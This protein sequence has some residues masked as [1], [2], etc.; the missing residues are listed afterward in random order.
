MQPTPAAR[1]LDNINA[2]PEN[3][4]S[5]AGQGST[6]SL[7]NVVDP[8]YVTRPVKRPPVEHQ[9]QPGAGMVAGN[10]PNYPP[11]AGQGSQS[12][13]DRPSYPRDVDVYAKPMKRRPQQVEMSK[14]DDRIN[15]ANAAI[16]NEEQYHSAE[17]LNA[18][19]VT[20]ETD[21]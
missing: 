12:S 17:S 1:S 16:A 19:R 15:V 8:V 3:Y 2:L 20:I 5:L 6:S 4:P 7:D 9:Q 10:P 13:L 14:S 18:S 11:L 21:V